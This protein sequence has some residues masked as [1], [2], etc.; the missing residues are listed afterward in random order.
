MAE[1]LRDK[2]ARVQVQRTQGQQVQLTPT[3][4][5]VNSYVAPVSVGRDDSVDQLINS[6]GSIDSSLKQYA[7]VAQ[8]QK[9]QEQETKLAFYTH[10][11]AK[12][13]QV[14]AVD[15]AQ[16]KEVFPELVPTIAARVAQA[17]GEMQAKQWAQDKIQSVLED[18]NIRLNTQNRKAYLDKVRQEAQGM[19]GDN[20][21]Y[22]T[23]FLTQLD[24]SLNEY[25]SS[26]ARETAAY[27]E[28][29]QAESFAG[30][31]SDALNKGGDLEA[32]DEQ[33]KASS[34]LNNLQRNK[35]VIETALDVAASKGDE[36]ILQSIPKRFLNAEA[37]AKFKQLTEQIQ[38]ARYSDYIRNKQMQ[39]YQRQETARSKLQEA[40]NRIAK[41]EQFS[42]LEYRQYPEIM[43][44][45]ARWQTT[46]TTS[47]LDSVRN[48]EGIT[49][50]IFSAATTGGF[51]EAFKDDLLFQN[52]FKDDGEVSVERM[53]DYVMR[54]SDINP[55]EKIKLIEQMPSIMEGVNFLR[56]PDFTQSYE[57]SVGDDVKTFLQSPFGQPLQKLGYNVQG[58]VR[59]AYNEH[60]RREVA[61]YMEDKG[62]MPRGSAKLEILQ[63]AEDAAMK[64]LQYIQQHSKELMRDTATGTP[65]ETPDAAP[66]KDTGGKKPQVIKLPNGKEIVKY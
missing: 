51:K 56:N 23:G 29:V 42:P 59:G 18:S 38:S 53:R 57:S 64:K 41:G 6:L 21:F 30:K 24:Q 37:K 31:V 19:V 36:K 9:E 15:A 61:A 22:G 44:N 32:L 5:P 48:A 39:E 17:T 25:E 12:D 27:H 45:I 20:E 43:D 55:Q 33:W 1:S 3:S 46:T 58:Q 10:Q 52:I 34:S 11:F 16:V 62:E 14:G 63:R 60:L 26:W 4:A 66:A 35:L 28:Q 2:K 65:Q 47:S 40:L 49:S 50:K 54:R 13:R 7:A 8:H